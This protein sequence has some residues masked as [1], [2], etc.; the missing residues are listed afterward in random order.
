[1]RNL[2]ILITV[3]TLFLVGC[4]QNQPAPTPIP[5]PAN[6]HS[7]TACVNLIRLAGF[8]AHAKIIDGMIA[9]KKIILVT[10]PTLNDSINAYAWIPQKEIWINTPLFARYPDIREQAS[11]ILHEVIHIESQEQTH[12]G[13]MW[14]DIQVFEVYWQTH[15]LPKE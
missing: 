14:K 13:P 3:L 8:E 5:P 6:Y 10:P 12:E 7:P 1:M 4:K 2:R 15:P 9:A 11:I